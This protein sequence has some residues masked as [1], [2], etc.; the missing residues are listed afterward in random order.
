MHEESSLPQQPPLQQQ[1]QQQD[2]V[3]RGMLAEP[4]DAAQVPS[5]S[6]AHADGSDYSALA[7]RPTSM[8]CEANVLDAGTAQPTHTSPRKSPRDGPVQPPGLSLRTG[9]GGEPAGIGKKLPRE[10]RNLAL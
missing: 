4:I 6:S 2:G 9:C 8:L 1:Q 3:A 7:D 10:L 5:D